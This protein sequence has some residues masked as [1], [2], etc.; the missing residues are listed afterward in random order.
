MR[1]VACAFLLLLEQPSETEKK[2]T[3]EHLPPRYPANT[4]AMSI[5]NYSGGAVVAMAG[6]ECFVIGSDHRLGDQIKTIATN[7]NK[8]EVINDTTVI[9]LTGLR[10]D[11]ITFGNKLKFNMN[12]YQLR[13]ERN[14]GGEALGSLVSNML[15][16]KRFGPYF[17]EP[18]I[19]SLNAD[20]SVYMCGTDL[21]G[22]LCEPK[23]Y[24]VGGTC[25][26]SL[27]GMCEALWSPDMGP[28]EL[29][30]VASQALLS[31]CDRDC[32]SGYG[33]TFIIVSKGKM[34]KKIVAGRKD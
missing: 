18:V 6:K 17:T 3:A 19:A 28:D 21:I 11:Q 16:E 31:A 14:I 20:G 29:F 33:A 13:E 2:D 1:N 30:E 12:M 4:A 25:G 22:A 34:V 8:L 9:G 24:V 32:L 10:S 27:H 5:M 15:Y 7:V 26:D 23:D